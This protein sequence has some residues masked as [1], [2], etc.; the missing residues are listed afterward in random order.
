MKLRA[1]DSRIGLSL[2]G[3]C[4]LM[5]SGIA[6]GSPI[7]GIFGFDGPGVLAFSTTGAFIDFCA[8][9]TGT[10]CN[11]NGTGT[12]DFTVTGPGTGSFAALTSSTT[13]TIDDLT[14]VTPPAPGYTYLP[15]GVPTVVNNVITLTGFPT[16]N[17]QADLLPLASCITST[18]Q[19][20]LGPFQLNQNG[21][22]VSVELNIDGTIINTSDGTMSSFDLAIT[23]NYLSTTISAV[24]TGALS[25]TGIL[26]NNWSGS[27]IATPLA[28]TPEPATSAM[29]LLGGGGLLLLARKRRGRR[30]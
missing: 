16:W 5:T 11:N 6:S 27:L 12:G 10:T 24:E 7:V 18:T 30:L 22:N 28:T 3:A 25:P 26:S 15:V 19:Q 9:V 8:T 17:F 20:C 23:G 13:G 1:L 29:L 21:S 4:L 2:L 14:D